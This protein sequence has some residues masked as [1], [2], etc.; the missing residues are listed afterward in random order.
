MTFKVGDRVRI[1]NHVDYALFRGY[2]AQVDGRSEASGSTWLKPLTPR[3]D[4]VGS[5][6]ADQYHGFQWPTRDLTLVTPQPTIEAGLDVIIDAQQA[7]DRGRAPSSGSST[8][9]Q[10]GKRGKVTAKCG[11]GWHVAIEGVSGTRHILTDALRV[12]EP[13]PT[14]R[15]EI[16]ARIEEIQVEVNKLSTERL[17]LL[18]KLEALAVKNPALEQETSQY[19]GYPRMLLI[20][21]VRDYN[22]E[23]V[24][25][26]IFTSD[27]DGDWW[28]HKREYQPSD[29]TFYT[30]KEFTQRF[31]NVAEGNFT[32]LRYDEA[33]AVFK[34]LG[35]DK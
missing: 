34:S 27:S 26:Q 11:N 33:A 9:T 14:T 28:A 29:G 6:R 3:P 15:E 7:R 30:W 5:S 2:E 1:G 25:L 13:E 22:T 8:V 4:M 35:Y 17:G 20:V 10:D 32:V 31:K 16:T 24:N 21:D 19:G 18:D 23:D 12:V